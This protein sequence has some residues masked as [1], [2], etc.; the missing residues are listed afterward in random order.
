[1]KSN[2]CTIIRFTAALI[3]I[4]A[5]LGRSYIPP[6]T[7]QVYPRD[8][9][10]LS[11]F[12]NIDANGNGSATW[13][14]RDNNYWG[15]DF[16]AT[17][18]VDK[19]CGFSLIW[20]V[21]ERLAEFPVTTDLPLCQSAES[22]ADGDGL[23]WE[24]GR[25]CVLPQSGGDAYYTECKSGLSDADGD[26]WGWE[27][28]QP[29]ILRA[30]AK[31]MTS[32]DVPAAQ[33][34]VGVD[35]SGYD[36]LRLHIYYE[37]R[38]KHLRV[39]MR[40]HN[41]AY[42]SH[43]AYEKGKYMSVLLRT[44]DLKAGPASIRLSEFSVAEWW[45]LEEGVPREYSMPEFNNIVSMGI[46]HVDHGI[47]KMR[48]QRIVL[49]GERISVEHFLTGVLLAWVIYLLFETWMRY[50]QLNKSS[51][52]RAIQIKALALESEM[53]TA[54]NSPL[55]T[56]SLTDLLT[57]ICNRNGLA[58]KAQELMDDSAKDMEVGV[59]LLEID[60]FQA[61]SDTYG[62]EFSDKILRIFVNLITMNIRQDDIFAR[63]GEEEFVILCPRA[64]RSIVL[65]L[66][67]KLRIV[68][69]SYA[70]ES[71]NPIKITVSIGGTVT[72]AGSEFTSI[73][74]RVD[75]ALFKAKERRNSFEFEP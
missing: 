47:H 71:N 64:S 23:G 62:K 51:R 68:V 38:A 37:G 8:N 1:M 11:L 58:K 10:S 63:W 50:Q 4:V 24:N 29:C 20:Q 19:F 41:S 48:V 39:F 27:N 28:E 53:M 13:I 57:G 14:D 31:P 45:I 46:D 55:G 32:F 36:R 16:R 5:I 75:K 3:T 56:Q 54:E 49:V 6:K 66:G 42:S 67:E 73:F 44:D 72:P 70:F 69:A 21:N 17:V 26:G 35:F 33:A 12:S 30:L 40:N 34:P 52:Q 43:A 2:V 22:D 65:S 9:S 59:L 15:C 18:G 7:M 74:K 25:V 61:L 60:H